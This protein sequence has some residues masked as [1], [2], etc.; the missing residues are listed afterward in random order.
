MA[1]SIAKQSVVE[2]VYR[3]VKLFS[4]MRPSSIEVRLLCNAALDY[5]NEQYR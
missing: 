4:S 2:T 1:V 5:V 3:Y